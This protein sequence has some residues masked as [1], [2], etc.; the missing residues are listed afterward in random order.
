MEV[1]E[2]RGWL[3]Q[4]RFVDGLTLVNL[5]PGPSSAQLSLFL[6]YIRAGW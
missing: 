5:L 6:G 1:Q 3:S 2:K 4:A